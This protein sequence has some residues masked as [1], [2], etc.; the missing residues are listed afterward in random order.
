MNRL[1]LGCLVVL[2]GV[3]ITLASLAH[4]YVT[5]SL[6]SVLLTALLLSQSPIAVLKILR[7]LEHA[8]TAIGE[9]VFAWRDAVSICEFCGNNR[10]SRHPEPCCM[11]R[12]L[13]N[14]DVKGGKLVMRV[15]PTCG[16]KTSYFTSKPADDC[17]KCGRPFPVGVPRA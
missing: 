16:L 5:A 8:L 17:P 11:H 7:A 9:Q 1:F 14:A 6:F 10:L 15:C 4:D 3:A 13:H 2:H 12:A